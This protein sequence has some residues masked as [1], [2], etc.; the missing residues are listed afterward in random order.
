MKV[1][2]VEHEYSGDHWVEKIFS[3]RQLAD[4]YCIRKGCSKRMAEIVNTD[5]RNPKDSEERMYVTELVVED[6]LSM[7]DFEIVP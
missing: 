5:W 2:V 4:E 3:S 6:A 1:Y 7:E